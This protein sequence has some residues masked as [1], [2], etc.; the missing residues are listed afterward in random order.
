MN[1]IA[2]LIAAIVF[3]AILGWSFGRQTA[4]QSWEVG[5]AYQCGVL[6][7]AREANHLGKTDP[8]IEELCDRLMH[9]NWSKEDYAISDCFAI[10][11]DRPHN[12]DGILPF[13][14]VASDRMD[15]CFKTIR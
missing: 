10:Y 4:W 5:K 1:E 13:D 8:D 12:S 11:N 14:Q 9:A 6:R 7:Q 3:A 15:E 2:R